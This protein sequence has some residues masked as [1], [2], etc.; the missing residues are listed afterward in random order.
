MS[1]TQRTSSGG[2]TSPNQDIIDQQAALTRQTMQDNLAMAK[3]QATQAL[4]GKLSGR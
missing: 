1:S 2:G 3:L 4:A